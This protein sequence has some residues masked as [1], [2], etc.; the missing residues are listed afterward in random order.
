MQSILDACTNHRINAK[1]SI[2]ISNNSRAGAIARAWSQNIPTAH[3]S[4]VTHGTPH[5]LDNAIHET[6]IQHGVDVIVLAG[7]MKRLGPCVLSDY[8]GRALNTHPALLPKFGGKGMYGDRVHEAV[9]ASREK[10]SGATVHLV[11]SEYDT[12]EV[13]SQDT[14]PVHKWDTVNSLRA[15]VQ[16]MERR[17]YV[18][19][20]EKIAAR[21]RP[22]PGLQP[23]RSP[24]QIRHA[25]DQTAQ[26]FAVA[27]QKRLVRRE[28]VTTVP[29]Q[30]F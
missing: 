2:V 26:A 29:A 22:L 11:E 5:D 4:G 25:G 14:V 21:K 27:V 17:H 8:W 10:V 23:I 19:V 7:Y 20:L 18:S 28:G 6:L 16:A 13:I 1:V 24:S 12:G 3:L 30:R 15:R 9:L